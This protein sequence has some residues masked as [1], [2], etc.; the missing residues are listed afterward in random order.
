MSEESIQYPELT[1]DLKRGL[2]LKSLKYF[3]AGAIMASV[4]IGSGETFFASRGGAIF[5]Y[6]LLWCFVASAIMK[7][8]QVYAA[9]RHMTLTG[10][11]PMTHWGR[12]PGP[13][14]WVPWTFT[15]L[16]LACFPF[17]LAGLPMFIGKTINWIFSIKGTEAELL[18]YARSWGTLVIV[19]AV[20]FTWF[21]TYRALER[22][23]TIIVGML[24]ISVLAACFA[25]QPDWLAALIGT[26]VPN[27]P[28]YEPWVQEKY[29]KVAG[30][31]IWIAI[32]GFLGAIGGG[33]YDYIGY[34]G[35]FREK[36][37]GL[38]G[39]R[40]GD[41]DTGTLPL[42]TSEE[43][44][45]RGRRWLLPARIDVGVGFFCVLIFTICFVLLGASMLHSEQIVPD[46]IDPLRHQAVF[47]TQFH[48]AMKFLY[49]IG[50][51]TAFFGTIYGAYEIYMRTAQECLHPLSER[52]RNLPEKKFRM[53]I[54][55]YCALGGLA[56]LWTM[57]SPVSI[58]E[59]AAIVGGVFACGLW[60]FAMIWADKKFLPK[61]LQM[62]PILLGL[63]AISGLFL[64]AL[65]AKA[66]I[67]YLNKLFS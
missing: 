8:V 7:G 29:P 40:D 67:D 42:D 34:V 53:I 38:I 52:V 19:V 49:Q 5:G 15:F 59:P 12:M 24:L 39:T 28:D 56:L 48:P 44:V 54:L 22:A 47:L 3:G 55:A 35:C 58:V 65:G 1:D 51:F 18:L 9:A 16:S 62:R 43:N 61:P 23:Q 17:W 37:W 4:T 2:S 33:T 32:G 11:H 45:Q 41:D 46:S 20:T 10:V 60:C 31:A 36:K 6:V 27:V 25:A 50:I 21:Q 26:F 30:K 14:N 13:R 66:I 63:T 57:D 64:T